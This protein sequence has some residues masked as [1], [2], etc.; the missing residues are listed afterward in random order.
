MFFKIIISRHGC[1][2]HLMSDSGSTFIS[3]EV[4]SLCKCF[5]IIK[6]EISPYH[7]QA[8]GKVEKFI[9]FLKRTLALITSQDKLHRWDEMIDHCLYVYECGAHLNL[10]LFSFSFLFIF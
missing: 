7:P 10:S 6:L 9:Y 2:E 3:K 1:S 4:T 5:N 8:N